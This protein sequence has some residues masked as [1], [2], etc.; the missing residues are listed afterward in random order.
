MTMRSLPLRDVQLEARA[1]FVQVQKLMSGRE[2]REEEWPFS[3]ELLHFY[4]EN[5]MIE[6]VPGLALFNGK[7]HCAR[8]GNKD[9]ELFSAYSCARCGKRCAY[10]RTCLMMGVVK[11]CT[12]LLRWTGSAQAMP[13]VNAECAWAGHLTA[14]QQNAADFVTSC[15][16]NQ[17]DGLIWAV[18]GAGKTEIL[19][20]GIESLIKEGK[21]VALA[22]P[23][24]DVVLEL[25]P[26]F[27]RAFP[28]LSICAQ[29]GDGP[30]YDPHA[31]LVIT[32]TH[33]LLRFYQTFDAMIIDE[34]DAFPF[35]HDKMLSFCV[36]KA[37]KPLAPTLYLTATPDK[38]LKRRFLA[39]QLKGVKIPI[40]YHGYAL[41][42]PTLRWIGTW[43]AINRK[44]KLPAA[45]SKW[46]TERA[47][48]GHSLF[49]FVP[50]VAMLE[51][52]RDLVKRETH[53]DAETVHAQDPER[54]EKVKR[55]RKG[56]V[57]ILLTTTILERGITISKADVAVFGAD[58]RVFDE[59]A[60]VQMAGRA[61][62][63]ASAPT[64]DVVFF[65]Y[66]RTEEMNRAVRHIR[67]MNR[68]GGFK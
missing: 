61:G 25:L 9:R 62:R 48:L 19:F 28:G 1:D 41:P 65:H 63:D 68:E 2:V 29:Y 51:P 50:S 10:C 32:T 39:S 8:C 59:R 18:C 15:F 3:L 35:S 7:N 21:R 12:N 16:N 4:I 55:F 30:D 34:V 49:V 38:K 43:K 66:G 42:V 13:P 37:L 44:K 56:E 33:Q 36:S 5:G 57:T 60:L 52:L 64:G 31:P 45:F 26:R 22:T 53:L 46:V 58:D 27:E 11:G 17:E 54:L 14:H 6:K 20:Q 23:R 67:N 47:A 40:R 24:K